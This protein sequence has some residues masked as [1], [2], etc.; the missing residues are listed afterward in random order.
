MGD[1]TVPQVFTFKRYEKRKGFK[2]NGILV[3][4]LKGAIMQVEES[5]PVIFPI[6]TSEE[7]P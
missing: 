4:T 5:N 1:L 3:D 2:D 6:H 7:V